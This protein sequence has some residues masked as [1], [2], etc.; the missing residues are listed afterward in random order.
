[1]Q[2]LHLIR[3]LGEID[4][5]L[6]AGDDHFH[7]DRNLLIAHA[8]VIEKRLM[9]INAVRYR[10]DFFSRRRL[11]LIENR[12]EGAEKTLLMPYLSAMA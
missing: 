3:H 5:H 8:V 7:S 10:A 1:M 9:L 6:V 12:L 11:A 2:P 4:G